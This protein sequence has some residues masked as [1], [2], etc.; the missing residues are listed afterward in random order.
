[1]KFIFGD[2]DYKKKYGKKSVEM[3]ILLLGQMS[4]KLCSWKKCG[5]KI[6][7][8]QKFILLLDQI[9]TLQLEQAAGCVKTSHLLD[10]HCQG[11]K[12][13]IYEKV[14]KENLELKLHICFFIIRR[15]LT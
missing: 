4:I 2:V 7:V 6:S 9:L 12:F 5:K 1:M 13:E 11:W 8:I 3:F 10:H 15:I 14:A